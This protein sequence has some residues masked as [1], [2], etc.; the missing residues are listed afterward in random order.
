MSRSRDISKGTT[1]NEFVFTA[2]DG[3]T[4][5]STDDTSTALAYSVGK[6]DVFLNGIRLAPAD[7]TATN[8]TSIV[9]A[10]GANVNDVLL[11]ISYGT[12]QVADLGTALTSALDIGSQKITGSAVSLDSSGNITLDADGAI[13]NLSD[14]GTDFGRL[15]NNGTNFQIQSLVSDK[16]LLFVG[17]D[18]GS[19]ITALTIDM[20]AAGAATFN[21]DVTAFSDVILKDD[22]NTIDNALARV[23]GMRGVFFNR[24]DNSQTRQT[25]VI[26]Q[27]V[28]PFLPEV[29]RET[30]DEKKIKSVAYGNMV[31]VLI[32]AIKELNAKIE[33]LQHA[34]KE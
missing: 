14:G 15:A 21:N 1:R 29:V 30:K 32:E 2:T 26:A 17:N 20:S 9:L 22:I 12:F 18:G 10:S 25:G 27:E 5:F 3:Q 28:Q 7:F 19:E 8:G 6:T 16:D 13:I 24:K 33:E 34:D 4:T 23:T 11:V 31:G